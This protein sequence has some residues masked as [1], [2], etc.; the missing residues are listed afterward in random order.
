MADVATGGHRGLEL[1]PNVIVITALSLAALVLAIFMLPGDTERIA[2]LERDGHYRQALTALEERF[3][4]GDRR[5]PTLFQLF[6]LHE[7]HG[8]IANARRM[9]E[10]L[11]ELRPNDHH[12]Q[13]Q[14][15]EFYKIT[16]D[17]DSYVRALAR[18]LDIRYSE[19]A[20]RNLIGIWRRRGEAD[21][22]QKSIELCRS[23]GY[24]RTEDIIRLGFLSAAGGNLV[25][26]AD[27]LRAVDDRRRLK[28][29]EERH[30]LFAALVEAGQ[31][32]EANR[33]AGRWL[34]G[35]RNDAFALTLIDTL[36]ESRKFDAAVDLAREV[37]TVGDSVSLV[38]ASL[39]TEQGQQVAA[40]AYLR[41]WLE[42]AV[43][44]TE[45]ITTRFLASALDAEDSELAYIGAQRYGLPK[46][47]QSHLAELAEALGADGRRK[48]F[49]SVR[50][51]L[52][53]ETV[54]A[55][56]LLAAAIEAERGATVPARVLLSR[57]NVGELEE[58]RLALWSR[59]METTGRRASPTAVPR[60]GT[61]EPTGI[62]P[63]SL[64]P[65]R[66]V[67][68]TKDRTRTI[69]RITRG[70]APPPTA[71]LGPGAVP[72]PAPGVAPKPFAPPSF[73]SGG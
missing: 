2:V 66:I 69:R 7:R 63:Q 11:V 20:C 30:L 6:K 23:K 41:G 31:E 43:L 4:K 19:P 72:G 58:W 42:K 14:L 5:Q 33:R 25:A 10:M 65:P 46:L 56:P 1:R 57:V 55:N 47:G 8:D 32:K 45:D 51:H 34:R 29:D 73:S 3:A 21:T 37:G 16:Q 12:L 52:A 54:R 13:R 59:L 17:E 61:G 39:M 50:S 35:Q 70:K 27:I 26:A 38:I 22:E 28:L 44:E 18:Q 24:R 48:E 67:R 62:G 53:E 40:R 71:P 36:V 60:P 64:G 68:R 9:L 49:R 15:A